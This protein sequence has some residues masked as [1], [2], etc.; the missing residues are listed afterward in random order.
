[1][2]STLRLVMSQTGAFEKPKYGAS[3]N[4]NGIVSLSGATDYYPGGMPMSNRQ[5]VNGEA[6]RYGYQGN[7]SEKDEEIGLNS[8]ERR[9]HVLGDTLKIDIVIRK[10]PYDSIYKVGELLLFNKK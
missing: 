4:Q 6:Y 7:F 3:K 8:F 9:F 5:I 1:M 10:P 2:K